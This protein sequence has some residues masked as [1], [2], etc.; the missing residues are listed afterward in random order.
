GM[1]A[2]QIE[3]NLGNRRADF[4]ESQ[5]GLNYLAIQTG[6]LSIRNTNDLNGGI[7][8]VVDDQK[9]YYL[10][11]YRPDE[12]TFDQVSGRRKFHKL[13]L[14]VTRPGKYNVRMRNGFYGITDEEAVPVRSTRVQQMVGAL[15]S[16]FGSA[17]VHLRLT[18]LFANDLQVGSGMRSLL[19]VDARD[20]TFTDEPDG[21][22]KSMF[23]VLAITFGDNGVVVDQLSRTHTMR[24]KGQ[25]HEHIL[26]D[27]FTYNVIVPIK[28]PGAYQ[29]RTALRDS[30]SERIGSATQFIEVP[31]LKKNRLT[32]SGL[33]VAGRPIETFKKEQQALTNQGQ[34]NDDSTEE[35]E[36]NIA[37]RQFARGL[38][39]T[40]RFAIYN[41]QL[42][43]TSG[44][45]QLLTQVRIFRSGQQIFAGKEAPLDV[46]NQ[47]DLKRIMAGGAIQLGVEMTPGEYVLQVVVTDL[48]AKEKYRIATQWTDFEVIK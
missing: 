17:G 5:S 31:D 29:F 11:G 12:S 21:W 2:G 23:D 6:G 25:A 1:T 39:M 48:L 22:H 45:P 47:P 40:H 37:R 9:G 41:A 46:G 44:K 10:V 18:T 13:S 20:L 34:S 8:R 28:K 7:R 16:P 3:E 38:V 42:D 4:F 35:P 30:A 19:H 24:V 36:G 33:L 32:L 14:K 43:K 15:T 26:K 27:G